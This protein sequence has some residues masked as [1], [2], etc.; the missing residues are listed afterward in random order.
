MSQVASSLSIPK[1]AAQGK[2]V[3]LL[4]DLLGSKEEMTI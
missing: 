2:A 4:L 1:G 3:H